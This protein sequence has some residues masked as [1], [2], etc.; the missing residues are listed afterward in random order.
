MST[1]QDAVF[2]LAIAAA[3]GAAC[4]R[5]ARAIRELWGEDA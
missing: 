5:V 4:V 1:L 2:V 3:I